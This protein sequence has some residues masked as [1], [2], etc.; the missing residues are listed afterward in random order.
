[1]IRIRNNPLLLSY[2]K[3]YHDVA[4]F[5]SLYLALK[6]GLTKAMGGAP[7]MSEYRSLEI[8]AIRHVLLFSVSQ[9]VS[10][11]CFVADLYLSPWAL[12]DWWSCLRT[13]SIAFFKKRC[14]EWSGRKKSAMPLLAWCSPQQAYHYAHTAPQ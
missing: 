4:F 1:M 2:I 13:V 12:V 8:M 11:C 14:V 7:P 3:E 9:C 10:W 5:L 6:V